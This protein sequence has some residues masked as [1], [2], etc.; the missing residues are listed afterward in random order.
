[1]FTQALQQSFQMDAAEP[2]KFVNPFLKAL[3]YIE[4]G[5]L[6]IIT[7]ERTR[8]EFS[9][10]C[11]GPSA[12]MRLKDW[13]VFDDLITRGEIGLARAYIDGRWDSPDLTVFLTFGLMNNGS[14]EDFF[15]GKALYA[16]WLRVKSVMRRNSLAGSQRNI[17][18]H[19]DLGN[20]F[21]ALWLDE[22]MT[23]SCALFDGDHTRS[24]QEAQQAKYQRILDKIGAKP[25]DHVLDMGCG[26]GGFAMAAAKQGLKITAVTISPRQAEYAKEHIEK[27]GAGDLASVE[28]CDYREIK[29]MFDHIVS[30]G[31]FE[32]IGEKYWPDYFRTIKAHLKPGGTAMVQSITLDAHIFETFRHSRG[33]IET[34]IFPGGMLPS[35]FRFEEAAAKQGLA[36]EEKFSF[37]QD[38][39][40]TIN[41]WLAR[42]ESHREDIIKLGYDEPFIRLWRFYLSSCIASFISRRCDVMQAKLSHQS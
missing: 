42:F 6:T 34:Y 12:M 28:L 8:L 10:R 21:Y 17:M 3:Q 39:A 16:L 7:P 35:Q 1:M 26:W 40:I 41:R 13:E 2:R 19:Y 22:S 32:H 37:G 38:Y 20:D 36:C 30:I 23:Y 11:P 27:E 18:E 15:H 24:L 14:L 31:M 25:G 29:G 33:F 4:Y 5:R 9:G